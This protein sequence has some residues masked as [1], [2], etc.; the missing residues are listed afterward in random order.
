VRR[1]TRAEARSVRCPVC[2]ASPGHPCVEVRTTGVAGRHLGATR[3]ANHS[4]RILAFEI[5]NAGEPLAA[6]RWEE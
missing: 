5:Q 1:P 2:E 3:E 4:N 6:L